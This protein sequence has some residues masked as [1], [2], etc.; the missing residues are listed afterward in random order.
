MGSRNSIHP[1]GW[2]DGWMEEYCNKV[3]F[4]L[5]CSDL[6]ISTK[7]HE[8]LSFLGSWNCSCA[9]NLLHLGDSL[10]MNR[11]TSYEDVKMYMF[12][13]DYRVGKSYHAYSIVYHACKVSHRLKDLTVVLSFKAR[14]FPSGHPLK[15]TVK[16]SL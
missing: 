1:S 10:T 14:E 16:D 11:I 15:Q 4:F 7:I 12:K 13:G 3:S 9:Q 2:M 8:S 6:T 5:Q